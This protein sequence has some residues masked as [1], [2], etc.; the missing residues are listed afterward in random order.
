MPRRRIIAAAA[1]AILVFGHHAASAD[2]V[3]D[4]SSNVSTGV[5]LSAF[6][7]SGAAMLAGRYMIEAIKHT[8][9]GVVLVL[10]PVAE[11][12]RTV[13]RLAGKASGH[14]VLAVGQVVSATATAAGVLV[15]ASGRAIALIPDAGARHLLHESTYGIQG[16]RSQRICGACCS[17]PSGSCSRKP[18]RR[19]GRPVARPRQ[20][21]LNCATRRQR[22]SIWFPALTKPA[23][24]WR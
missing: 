11:G 3:T 13:L 18:R 1:A 4:L 23:P 5:V 2:S 19:R 20:M 7:G 14:T 22:R 16:S 24:A 9:E 8:A 12:A 10:R 6:A 17:S 21:S 15:T